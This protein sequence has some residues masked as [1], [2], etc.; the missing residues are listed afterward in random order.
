MLMRAALKPGIE[1]VLELPG[2]ARASL[3]RALLHAAVCHHYAVATAADDAAE[4]AAGAGP[5][6]VAPPSALPQLPPAVAWPYPGRP[7]SEPVFAA[8]PAQQQAW[9]IAEVLEAL[10]LPLK[11]CGRGKAC[12]HTAAR[13]PLHASALLALFQLSAIH[14]AAEAPPRLLLHARAARA[15][16]PCLASEALID[17][18]NRTVCRGGG[19]G[20]KPGPEAEAER[21]QLPFGLLLRAPPGVAQD[22]VVSG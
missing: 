14:A 8:L 11:S 21:L 19:A 2:P 13:S 3:A 12:P 5:G 4:A 18:L 10:W 6:G 17:R 20:I 22:D 15:A 1:G 9:L 16:G 7:C